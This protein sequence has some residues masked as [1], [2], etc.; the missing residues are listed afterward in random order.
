MLPMASWGMTSTL[1]NLDFC[2]LWNGALSFDQFVAE[3]TTAQS[4]WRGVYRQARIPE[5]AATRAAAAAPLRLLVLAEDWCNDAVSTIP[6]LARLADEVPGIELRILRRDAHP[7]VMERYLS[8]GAR[9][10]P[11]VI[12]LDLSCNELGHWGS[13]PA[14]LEEWVGAHRA[15][16]KPTRNLEIRKWYARDRG[17]SVLREVLDAGNGE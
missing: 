15:L 17:A 10:I 12:V 14:A 13:R 9:A 16:D 11:I 2:A 5:W 3:A 7:E 1:L 6:I 4:L 8:D